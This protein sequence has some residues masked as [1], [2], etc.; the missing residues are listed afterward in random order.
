MGTSI[1]N[2]LLVLIFN[3]LIITPVPRNVEWGMGNALL[4]VSLLLQI[5]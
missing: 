3:T 4:K 1:F 2:I 5:P